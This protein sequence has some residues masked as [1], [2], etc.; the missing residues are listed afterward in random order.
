M[1]MNTSLSTPGPFYLPQLDANGR[2][3]FSAEAISINA[4]KL[5]NLY[6]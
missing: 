3:L 4:R 5:Q 6:S 2:L 1:F